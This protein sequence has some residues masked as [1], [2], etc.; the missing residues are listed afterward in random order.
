MTQ[1]VVTLEEGTDT[2][3]IRNAIRMIKGVKHTVVNSIGNTQTSTDSPRQEAIEKLA[4]CISLSDIDTSDE[5]S[6]YLLNK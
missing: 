5:R 6:Q 1:I 2:S 3:L 4:G